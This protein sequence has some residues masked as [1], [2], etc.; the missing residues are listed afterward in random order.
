M[1]N[2]VHGKLTDEMKEARVKDYMGALRD[3]WNDV[4]MSRGYRPEYETGSRSYQL[5]YERGR[6]AAI[7]AKTIGELKS[8]RGRINPIRPPM[9]TWKS[10][11]MMILDLKNTQYYKEI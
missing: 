10:M 11:G 1:Q 6:N 7:H 3:G 4:Y 8:W 5:N 2:M 9:F